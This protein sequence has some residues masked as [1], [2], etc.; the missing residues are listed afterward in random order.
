MKLSISLILFNQFRQVCSLLGGPYE[1]MFQQ[2]L[3]CWSLSVSSDSMTGVQLTALGSRCTHCLTKSW[4]A[5]ENLVSS[6]CGGGFLGM[7]NRTCESA[8]PQRNRS[9]C[10]YF[11]RMQIGIRRFPHCQLDSRDTF[12]SAVSRDVGGGILPRLQMSASYPYP[13]CL[14]TSGLIQYGVPTKVF[15]R[16]SR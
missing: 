6:S 3:C 13:D 1:F 2:F 9:G 12:M 5:R 15:Y 16:Q 11:H 7:M 4:N 14:I 10:T 8:L